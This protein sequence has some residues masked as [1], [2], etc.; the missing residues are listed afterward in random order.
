MRPPSPY[1]PIYDGRIHSGFF[2]FIRQLAAPS[3]QAILTRLGL[4]TYREAPRVSRF[5]RY[6]ALCDVGEWTVIADDLRYSLYHAGTARPALAELVP[7]HEIFVC[8][9]GDADRSFE[10][11]YFVNGVLARDCAVDSP[12][13]SDRKVVRDV[14]AASPGERE[15]LQQDGD[16][17]GLAVAE[18]LGIPTRVTPEALRIYA[19]PA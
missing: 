18:L 7:D 4:D 10:Y 12:L 16:F 11:Q 2:I 1:S 5:D 19:P 6:I 13:Y 3:D 17:I 8:V 9:E 15:L 14:G